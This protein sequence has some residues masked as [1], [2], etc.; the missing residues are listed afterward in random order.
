MAINTSMKLLPVFA[1]LL[2]GA[3]F[4]QGA[5]SGGG[6]AGASSTSGT[7]SGTNVEP[8]T[9]IQKQNPSRSS[10]GETQLQGSSNSAGAPAIEGGSNTQ[11]G[12][13]EGQTNPSPK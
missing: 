2:G 12:P 1:L 3:A 6:A 11:S 10:P 5:S 8:S 4:A 13:N 9:V 7:A